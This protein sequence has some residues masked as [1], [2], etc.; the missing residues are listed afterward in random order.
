VQRANNVSEGSSSSGLD[1]TS[2][3]GNSATLSNSA[4]AVAMAMAQVRASM[5]SNAN[6]NKRHNDFISGNIE[7]QDEAKR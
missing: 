6:N 3:Q 7:R 2:F 4:S 1:D 5:Q